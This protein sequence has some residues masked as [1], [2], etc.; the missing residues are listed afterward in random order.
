MESHVKF[1][2]PK[3]M[4]GASHQISIAALSETT[5]VDGVFRGKKTYKGSKQL[6]QNNPDLQMPRDQ[7]FQLKDVIVK[8][9]K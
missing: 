7:K 9:C 2:I 8:G 5:K 4:S 3:N 6:I 1:L